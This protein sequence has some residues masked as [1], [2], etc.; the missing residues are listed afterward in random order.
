MTGAM[1]RA[2]RCDPKLC[3][4]AEH[5][6]GHCSCGLPMAATAEA[7]QL[8]IHERLDP[9]ELPRSRGADEPE[10][11]D[12][13]SYPSRR[14]RR[15]GTENR[16]MY[17]QLIAFV[18]RPEGPEGLRLDGLNSRHHSRSRRREIDG[19]PSNAAR[20]LARDLAIEPGERALAEPRGG[21]HA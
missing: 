3:A 9:L 10:A 18:L 4:L 21:D 2:S 12:G 6:H 5:A 20:V 8:C 1:E 11:W 15:I 19:A 7:C 16:E 17:L 14:R 13:L